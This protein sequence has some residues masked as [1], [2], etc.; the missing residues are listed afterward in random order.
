MADWNSGALPQIQS[1]AQYSPCDDLPRASLCG[2]RAAFW[3]LAAGL[4]TVR[5]QWPRVTPARASGRGQ[6][7]NMVVAA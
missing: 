2:M 4:A 5:P 3:T 6:L 7:E 1:G